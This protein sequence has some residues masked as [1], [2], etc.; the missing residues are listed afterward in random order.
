[1]SRIAEYYSY[2]D[3]P[4]LDDLSSESINKNFSTTINTNSTEDLTGPRVK[5]CVPRQITRTKS[6]DRYGS[7]RRGNK[8]SKRT[9]S[10]KTRRTSSLRTCDVYVTQDFRR[11]STRLSPTIE[12][13]RSGSSLSEAVSRKEKRRKR[14]VLVIM[15]SFLVLVF[16]SVL[17]VVVT[18]THNSVISI[19]NVTSK[20]YTFA[21]PPH[22]PLS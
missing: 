5:P 22:H 16:A 7:E 18:L 17:V 8:R 3:I 11:Q 10:M 14:I 19:H 1:M 12:V 6:M 15:I 20:Y 4:F 9:T 21:A 2:P 13:T